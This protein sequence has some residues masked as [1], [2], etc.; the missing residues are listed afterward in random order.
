M[1]DHLGCAV[2]RLFSARGWHKT[3]FGAAHRYFHSVLD[4]Y[5]SDPARWEEGSDRFRATMAAAIAADPQGTGLPATGADAA[6]AG[7]AAASRLSR[8]AGRR[9]KAAAR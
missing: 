8:S 2:G 4:C 6:P 5:A 3:I 9:G 7:T 1:S